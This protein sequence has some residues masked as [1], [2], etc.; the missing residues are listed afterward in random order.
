MFNRILRALKMDPTIFSEVGKD[1][2]LNQEA[3]IIAIIVGVV[4]ALGSLFNPIL[5][6]V[7]FLFALVTGILIGWV[8]W[9]LVVKWIAG[10]QGGKSTFQEVL[11]A[12]AYA[13][14]PRMVGVLAFIPVLGPILVFAAGLYSA[15]LTVVAI[16]QLEGFDNT[17]AILTALA[18]W[19]VF[20]VGSLIIG[21]IFNSIM[22]ASIYGASGLSRF[23]K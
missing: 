12:M 8:L 6:F 20:F 7:S 23:I 3:T 4:A 14:V 9:S 2:S 15:W 18:A 10:L 11:R 19:A 1:T 5:G 21:A 22:A 13:G 17:K 16:R